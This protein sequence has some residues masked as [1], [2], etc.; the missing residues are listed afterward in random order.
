MQKGVQCDGIHQNVKFTHPLARKFHLGE[1]IL[2]INSCVCV[3]C[4]YK[5]TQQSTICNGGSS[6]H[7]HISLHPQHP[8]V[9]KPP[10]SIIQTTLF[11][12]SLPSSTPTASIVARAIFL[13]HKSAY[14]ILLLK[15]PPMSF[16]QA[17]NKIHTTYP[18]L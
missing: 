9:A 17:K 7:M 2:Q 5:D 6:Q 13:K 11:D 14:V 3:L 18:N 16:H 10:S 15:T 12:L 4:T 8:F 1:L